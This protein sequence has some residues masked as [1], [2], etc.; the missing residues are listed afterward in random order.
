ML[1]EVKMIFVSIG[2][3]LSII[4]CQ[5]VET[6]DSAQ[7]VQEVPYFKSLDSDSYLVETVEPERYLGLWYEYATIPAGAQVNCTAT[8]AEYSLIDEE[9]IEVYNRCHLNEV[10]GQLSEIKGT[11]RPTDDNYNHL[12]VNFF[13]NFEADY[14]IVSLDGSAEVKDTSYQWAVVSS[15]QDRVLWVLTRSPNLSDEDYSII[16]KD[17]EE[18]DFDLSS[19]RKT[20]HKEQ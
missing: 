11:A 17:L 16:L 2:I 1:S 9:T 7:F 10:D 4:G 5:S 12:R 19:L 6:E 18:R 13:G 14:Y 3:V 8:T 15:F 20:P